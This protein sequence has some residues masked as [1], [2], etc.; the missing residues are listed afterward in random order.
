MKPTPPPG[1]SRPQ[2]TQSNLPTRLPDLDTIATPATRPTP[3]EHQVNDEKVRKQVV[4]VLGELGQQMRMSIHVRSEHGDVYLRGT[5]DTSYNRL[6]VVS[7]V[8]RLPGVKKIHDEITLGSQ[9]HGKAEANHVGNGNRKRNLQFVGIVAAVVLLA[10]A[11]GA[12]SLTTTSLS[13]FPVVVLYAGKPADGAILTLHPLDPQPANEIKRPLGRVGPDGTVEWTTFDR[14]DGVPPGRYAVTAIWHP[15]VL[16]NGETFSRSN[17]LGK[18]Y[19]KSDSTPLRLE[20]S[21]QAQSPLQVEL[22]R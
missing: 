2:R 12:W 7:V 15:L 3:V 20:V 8:S 17:V 21:A 10:G 14:G 9:F 6:L 4:E 18:E 19:Q 5:V 22:K 11:Y 1:P 13:D 16:V